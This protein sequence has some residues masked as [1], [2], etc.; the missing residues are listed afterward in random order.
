[1]LNFISIVLVMIGASI[2]L[3]SIFSLLKTLRFFSSYAYHKKLSSQ[4]LTWA[5][6][7]MMAAF[8]LGYLVF[9][10]FLYLTKSAEAIMLLVAI[11]FFFG[12]VF[13]YS[14]V[15]MQKKM[16]HDIAE[17]SLETV[18]SLI[19]AVEAK[20]IYTKGH[21]EHVK[22]LVGV[23][24]NHLPQKYRVVVD[25]HKLSDA[26]MLHDIG[27]IG[28]PDAV[29]NKPS[30]L[31][32]EEYNI[33]K[34]HPERGFIILKNTIYQE[35]GAWILYHHERVDGNGYQKLPRD[36]IPLESKI[37]AIADTF[38]A[39]FTDRVYR[40]KHSFED[41]ITI[42]RESAGSQLEAELVEIFCSIDKN[43]LLAASLQLSLADLPVNLTT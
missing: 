24:Y 8:L 5:C 36:K 7:V 23:F 38:S 6:L 30:A 15:T 3:I 26:A 13:V 18:Y 39:L 34:Q 1:M 31:T 27:K 35:I 21:S 14:M 43:E 25:K 9:S 20:D 12:A 40:K 19:S 33:I 22:N 42:L 4:H 29:L 32:P 16:S 11:I 2:M 28:I 37:L 41:C 17:R 10:A